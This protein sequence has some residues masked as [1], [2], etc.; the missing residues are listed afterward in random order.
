[1]PWQPG[2]DLRF[3]DS[4]RDD[5]LGLV[6]CLVGRLV[7]SMIRSHC[8]AVVFSTFSLSFNHFYPIP[9]SCTCIGVE[10]RL[11]NG[12]LAQ[13]MLQVLQLLAVSSLSSF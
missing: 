13:P 1:M 5:C 6:S 4:Y 12:L 11:K 8:Y 7:F 9:C 10:R 3:L 2:V